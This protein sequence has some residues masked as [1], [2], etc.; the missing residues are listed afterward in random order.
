MTHRT[1]HLSN[2]LRTPHFLVILGLWAKLT[3]GALPTDLTLGLSL[4]GSASDEGPAMSRI[5]G[6]ELQ[7]SFSHAVREMA[8]LKVEAQLRLET[9]SARQV[10]DDEFKPRTGL[11]LKESS[12]TIT[13]TGYLEFTLGAVDQDRWNNPQ[14]LSSQ[15]FPSLVEKFEIGSPWFLRLEGL[16]AYASDTSTLQPWNDFGSASAAFFL[17]RLTIGR[18]DSQKMESRLYLSHFLFDGLSPALA[19]QS[20]FFGNSTSGLGA[21]DSRFQ[22]GFRGFEAGAFTQF[23]ITRDLR[24]FLS[25][26]AI[27]NTAAPENQRR[28]W[29]VTAGTEWAP[30]ETLILGSQ[31]EAFQMESDAGP[32]VFNSRQRGHNNRSGYGLRI[33]ATLP[34]QGLTVFGEWFQSRP[35]VAQNFQHDLNWIQINLRTDYDLL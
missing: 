5:A 17:E 33:S 22:S 23:E 31:L 27:L 1:K 11:R 3:S 19:Y 32:A 35:L 29:R 2:P 25:L 26:S 21:A 13:P 34:R 30:T 8:K 10:F 24:P 14:L 15:S 4:F 20:R 6:S 12:V 7:A 28:A 18:R 16:Q 9:G